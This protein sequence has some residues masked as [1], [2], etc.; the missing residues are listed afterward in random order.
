MIVAIGLLALS[1]TDSAANNGAGVIR[2]RRNR[3]DFAPLPEWQADR[4]TQFPVALAMAGAANSQ[5]F[6]AAWFTGPPNTAV[7]IHAVPGTVEVESEDGSTQAVL[8]LL[9]SVATTPVVFNA[10]GN[11]GP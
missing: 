5:L 7:Q 8:G 3:Q 2:L 10:Q 4:S 11:S 9:G 6:V 1:F